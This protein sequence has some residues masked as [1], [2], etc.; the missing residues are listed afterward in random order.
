MSRARKKATL[1][2]RDQAEPEMTVIIEVLQE[3]RRA[4]DN[5]IANA[6]YSESA[7]IERANQTAEELRRA[8]ARAE[9]EFCSA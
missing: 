5:Q 1:E 9:L 4:A 8:K 6:D 2:H 7:S 3:A